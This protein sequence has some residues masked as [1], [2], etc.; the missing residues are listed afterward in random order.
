MKKMLIC[1][2]AAVLAVSMMGCKGDVGSGSGEGGGSGYIGSK[3]PDEAKAVGDIVFT[4]GSAT[5]Y[6]A[7]L[8]LTDNQKSKSIAVIYK[9]DGDKVYG[10][11]EGYAFSG[12]EKSP[13]LHSIHLSRSLKEG[14]S[15]VFTW[16]NGYQLIIYEEN[17]TTKVK[18]IN[19]GSYDEI[20]Q[21]LNEDGHSEHT[22]LKF[23]D[24]IRLKRFEKIETKTFEEF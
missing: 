10:D 16:K 7:G 15:V 20:G 5:P 19:G 13:G 8:T 12:I 22:A 6:V 17:G 2:F 23:D 3:A 1:L 9:V 18:K 21:W 11:V 24:N 14:E 4:D